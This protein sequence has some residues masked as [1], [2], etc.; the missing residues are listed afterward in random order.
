MAEES[1]LLER[2]RALRDRLSQGP[3]P[4]MTRAAHA[5]PRQQ[6]LILENQVAQLR[7]EH[8]RLQQNHAAL[9]DDAPIDYAAPS[10]NG[11]LS[12]RLRRLLLNGRGQIDQLKQ[13]ARLFEQAPF[14]TRAP[15]PAEYFQQTHALAEY[16][17]RTV[18]PVPSSLD[19]Q[20]RLAD[21]LQTAL[22]DLEKR[23]H[24][25]QRYAR[26]HAEVQERLE[27]LGH[28]FQLLLNGRVF[29]LRSLKPL[30]D[31][32][33]SENEDHLPIPWLT[34]ATRRAELWS[35]AAAMNAASVAIRIARQ[36]VEWKHRLE[37]AALAALL[38]DAGMSA[39]PIELIAQSEKYSDEQRRS[40]ETHV[41]LAADALKTCAPAE[42][43]L[44]DA[45]RA[46]HERVDGSGYPMG[47]IGNRIPRLARILAV[48]DT[49]ASLCTT[50]PHRPAQSPRT[51]LNETLLEAERGRLDMEIAA[52]LHVLT[53][54]PIGS[55]VELSDGSIGSVMRHA[56]LAAP[57]HSPHRPLVQIKLMPD[58]QP[59][60]ST[61]LV[62]LE[63]EPHRQ[64][65]RGLSVEEGQALLGHWF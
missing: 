62:D 36:D 50:R 26:R 22:A 27:T 51:A 13:L 24:Q 15:G 16:C 28:A 60:L 57:M 1:N 10:P 12:W 7:L 64:I 53:P 59:A 47:L 2:L 46:H 32:L 23:L 52:H 41:G 19:D 63:R 58:M 54:Y 25:L 55:I 38:H 30:V 9:A 33:L 48:S 3:A 21:G 39:L 56:D 65:V 20:N 5:T 43:W 45:V 34:P 8:S 6:L 14:Q 49:Y 44:H 40:L 11:R 35:A 37:E 17:L 29:Q 18:E 4:S 42:G 31:V 61:N